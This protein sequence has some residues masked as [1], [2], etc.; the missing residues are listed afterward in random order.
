MEKVHQVLSQVKALLRRHPTAAKAFHTFYQSFIG[1]L[2]LGLTP[3]F[4]AAT[5]GNVH[6]AGV[7]LVALVSAAL[8]A[9][10]SAAKSIIAARIA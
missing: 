7:A 9:G 1:V 2:V 4:S 6:E 3:V 5:S 10:L 8:A